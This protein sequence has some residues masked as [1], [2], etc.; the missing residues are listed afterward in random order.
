M[1]VVD[2]SVVVPALVSRSGVGASSREV[3][4]AHASRLAAPALLDVEVSSAFRRLER[5]GEI[6]ASTAEGGVTGLAGMRIERFTHEPLL[7]RIWELRHNITPYDAAYVAVAELL[8]AP[9]V[10]LDRR[11]AK[12]SGIRCSVRVIGS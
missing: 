5:S 3:M 4:A 11:L 8:E 2:A 12:A 10:T 6:P 7:N 9:L 1:I